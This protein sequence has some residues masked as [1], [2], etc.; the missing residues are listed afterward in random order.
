[1]WTSIKNTCHNEKSLIIA[2]LL[3]SVFVRLIFVCFDFH[4]NETSKF[5]DDWLYLKLGELFASG[6]WNQH[7]IVAPVIPIIVSFWYLIFGSAI[8]PMIIYNV[9]IG[10]LSV[11][12]YYSLGKE[13]FNKHVGWLMAIW[14]VF[15]FE[16]FQYY[17]R[18]LKEP[19][20]FFLLPLT[21][22]FLYRS[23]NR[24]FEWKNILIAALAFILLIHTDERFVFY[25]PLFLLFFFFPNNAFSVKKAKPMILWGGLV[26]LLMMPWTIR[27]YAVYDQLVVLTPRTTAFT[28][29]IWG[30]NI[31]DM[32]F[33]GE[34]RIDRSA[35]IIEERKTEY[36]EQFGREPRPF[37]PNEARVRAFLYFWQPTLFSVTYI[38]YGH[39]SQGPWTLP[40]NLISLAF[41]GAFIPFYFLGLGLLVKRKMYFGLLFAL[42]PLLHS[43]LHAYMVWTLPRYRQP[44][45]FIIAMV[46]IW[47]AIEVYRF[48]KTTYFKKAA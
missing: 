31:Q 39:R 1:M 3:L 9:V 24:E 45:L 36:K 35:R 34:S 20:L 32:D 12:V 30:D 15:C 47:S 8:T 16:T 40:R 26:L 27:N 28:S 41:L 43:L 38:S 46:G 25:L 10:A 21:L 2:L 13:V 22:L 6:T 48:I 14:G 17:A 44:V 4:A 5:A 42:I 18:I 7:M 29:K 37:S 33:A 23:V 11:P 19:T